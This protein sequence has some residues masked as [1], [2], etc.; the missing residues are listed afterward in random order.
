MKENV[1]HKIY[2]RPWGTY[3]TLKIKENCQIKWIEVLPKG[4]LSLQ[5]H[6]KRSEHWVIV[7]GKAKITLNDEVKTYKN[8]DTFEAENSS[9]DNAVYALST[10]GG[11]SYYQ[12]DFKAGD[13]LVFGPETRGL[14]DKYLA[15]LGGDHVLR[16]PM[17][18][19]SRSLNL[20]NTVAI[21][22]YEALRQL[23]FEGFK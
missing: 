21:V 6:L 13:F 4:K 19:H 15:Q 14:P 12:A 10:K 3:Q 7:Q 9:S 11:K 22:T 18:E 16:L 23:R 8:I 5:K 20:S 17:L 2:K 1:E